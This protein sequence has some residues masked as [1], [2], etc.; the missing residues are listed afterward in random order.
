M[1][2]QNV[3]PYPQITLLEDFLHQG[4]VLTSNWNIYFWQLQYKYSYLIFSF[5][6]FSE[7][8]ITILLSEM[9][10]IQEYFRKNAEYFLV[11]L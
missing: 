9:Q 3:C 2:F 7:Y 8:S 5:F 6:S 1:I 11:P 4:R 10:K